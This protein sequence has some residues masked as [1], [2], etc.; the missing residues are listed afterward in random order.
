MLK[1]K[2]VILQSEDKLSEAL[3]CEL[4][5]LEISSNLLGEP[6]DESLK[7]CQR[8]GMLHLKL[9]NH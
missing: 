1:I 2:S 6:A 5:A 3:D 9:E 7:C 4:Q 8:L